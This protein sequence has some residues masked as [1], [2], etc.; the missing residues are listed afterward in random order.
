M[1]DERPPIEKTTKFATTVHGL[2]EA[3]SFVMSKLNE[4]DDVLNIEITPIWSSA[5]DF[6]NK[7]FG[8]AISGM[9]EL[10]AYAPENLT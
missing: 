2:D 3:F 10:P 6:T 7:R 5:D 9:I 8:V 4:V 1:S